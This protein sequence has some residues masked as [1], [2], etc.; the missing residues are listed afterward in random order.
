MGSCADKNTMVSKNN[1][2]SNLK[3]SIDWELNNLECG[4]NMIDITV[5]TKFVVSHFSFMR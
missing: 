1:Y 4:V 2:R 5:Y 3:F